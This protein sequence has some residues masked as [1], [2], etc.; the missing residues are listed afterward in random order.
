MCWRPARRAAIAPSTEGWRSKF[1]RRS[2]TAGRI[3]RW[4]SGFCAGGWGAGAD[5]FQDVGGGVARDNRKGNDTAAG[6]LH[7]FAA[8][9]LV[10]GP[11][12]AFD[13]HVGKQSGDDALRRE[14]VE[15]HHGVNAFKGGEDFGAFAFWNHRAALA[16][17]LADA[18]VAIEAD[19]QGVA[20]AAGLLEAADVARMEEIEA[21]VSEDELAAVA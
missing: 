9:D 16:F 20:E 8:D 14:V 7:F 11:V 21:A 18:G 4:Q 3:I 6:G 17:E 10:S 1:S 2:R 19:E 5:F 15:N 12:A 13:E